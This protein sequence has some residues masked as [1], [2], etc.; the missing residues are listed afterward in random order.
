MFTSVQVL[1]SYVQDSVFPHSNA[2]SAKTGCQPCR[3]QSHDCPIAHRF[4]SYNSLKWRGL[5]FACPEETRMLL[6][7]PRFVVR[8]WRW[9][10]RKFEV[11]NRRGIGRS[12][13]GPAHRPGPVPARR[14]KSLEIA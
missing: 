11:G 4:R 1:M 5:E 12:W 6:L 13:Y 10:I 9:L 7:R 14:D 3:G 2:E 8:R